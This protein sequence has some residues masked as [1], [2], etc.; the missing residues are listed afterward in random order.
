M[1]GKLLISA[2][3]AAGLLAVSIVAFAQSSAGMP[4]ST[5]V[6]LLEPVIAI[7]STVEISDAV[8]SEPAEEVSQGN[9]GSMDWDAEESYLLAK[10]A[11]AEAE[12]QDTEGKALVILVV[13][14]RVWD[15]RFPDTIH[16]VIY[17]ERQ[18]SPVA[19]GRFGRV[20]PNADCWQ[21][22]SMIELDGW[23][24]SMGAT[25]FE[26]ESESTWHEDNLQFLFQHGDHLFYT[27]KEAGK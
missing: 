6:M 18:F 20:E 24:E 25:Y 12:D 11:M 8:E 16:D 1:R 14:N 17:E 15:S 23:D 2:A 3:G 22:L 9:I 4:D 26:S 5:A 19:N 21:A 10:I 7:P 27:D 13:L